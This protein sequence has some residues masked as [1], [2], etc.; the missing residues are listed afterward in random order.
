MNIYILII[1]KERSDLNNKF[2]KYGFL[3]NLI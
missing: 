3:K 2:W 1:V